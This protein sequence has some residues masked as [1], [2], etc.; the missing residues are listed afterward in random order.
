MVATAVRGAEPGL[1]VAGS[2]VEAE[3]DEEE[4]EEEGS[5]VGFVRANAAGVT[6]TRA[7]AMKRVFCIGLQSD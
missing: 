6:A 7:R 1:G 3:L 4:P 2:D 5:T